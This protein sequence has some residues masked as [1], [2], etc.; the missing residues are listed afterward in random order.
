MKVE[1]YTRVKLLTD[2]Y[3]Q[4]GVGIGSIGY[5][6]EICP[7]EKYEVEFSDKNGVAIAQIVV[8]PD[9]IVIEETSNK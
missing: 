6:I 1:N 4:D 9:D 5:V 2:S 7:S 8:G 3:L